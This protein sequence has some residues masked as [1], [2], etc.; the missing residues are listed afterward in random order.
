MGN[1]VFANIIVDA[2]TLNKTFLFKVPDDLAKK[3]KRGDKVIFPFRKGNTD[4]E[5]FVLELLNIDEIK[6]KKFYKEDEYFKDENAIDNL[7]EIKGLALGK[8]VASDILLKIAIFISKEYLA[9]I[10][11]CVNAVLPVK[12]EVRKNKRQKDVL[13]NY[14]I[15]SLSENYNEIKLNDEQKKI[16]N[17]IIN[18]HKKN[19]F[20][21]HLVY[22]ITGSGK[23]EIYLNVIDEVLKEKKQV[24][25]LIPEIALT[26]QTVIRIKGKFG[27]NVA[28]IHSRMSEGEKYIQ[29]KKCET[30]ETNIMVGPRSALFAPFNN[31]GL[32]VIDEVQ[33]MSYKSDKT[34]RYDALTVARFRCLEQKATLI[35]L[36]ATPTISLYYD[37]KN[38][39]RILLH[40]L[41]KRA[42]SELPNVTIVDM[43]NENRNGN[44]SIFSKLLIDKINE[45]LK[46]NEQIMLFMNRRGY[47]TIF[48]CK[49]CGK[50]YKCPHCD[51]ALV[52]HSDG[53]MKCHYCGYEVYEPLKCPNCN[54]V[55]I[56]KY[57]IGTEKLEEMCVDLFPKAKILRMDRDTTA[58][59]G[60]HD[61][62]IDKFRKREADILIGTQM[63]IK[64][65]DFPYVTLVAVMRA[66]ILMYGDDYKSSEN[67]FSTITQ[68]IGRSGRKMFGESIVQ[69]YDID[70]NALKFAKEQDFEKFYEEEI[71]VRKKL[72]YPPF[73]TILNITIMSAIEEL[74]NDTV[75]NLKRL[76]ETKNKAD[77]IILGPAKPNPEKIQD[78]YRRSIIIKCKNKIIAKQFRALAYKFINI[79][80]KNGIVKITADIE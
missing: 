34:S 57:G 25:V 4:K 53:K 3:I 46:K 70:N 19:E 21:E 54:S 66:D 64:G 11:L 72:F 75:N 71:E 6:E 40:K 28:I 74:L 12:K 51:V 63:I 59:K 1:K 35:S 2:T 56:E 55:D 58:N 77:A 17:D 20:D 79:M 13:N 39:N 52:S 45:K 49:E 29:Y 8:M 9:P 38:N 31:L 61:K 42:S 33:D 43:K 10:S 78:M 18:S 73:S 37:A 36:S 27:N 5:G 48:T 68:C 62:I 7:K 30:G 60:A 65:H 15:E 41:S 26:H 47:D 16:I 44:Y 80:Y 24:I 69:A 23:T 50:T 22:G 14:D 67:A 32:I 76:L